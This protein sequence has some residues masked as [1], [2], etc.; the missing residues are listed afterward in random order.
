M[1]TL[2]GQYRWCKGREAHQLWRIGST[3]RNRV[4]TWSLM[5][6]SAWY[7]CVCALCHKSRLKALLNKAFIASVWVV[8]DALLNDFVQNCSVQRPSFSTAKPS[9]LLALSIQLESWT[10]GMGIKTC[11]SLRV[12]IGRNSS[13]MSLLPSCRNCWIVDILENLSA[14]PALV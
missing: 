13:Y 12:P 5:A 2:A 6:G 1:G 7:W 10:T 11:W 9:P 4:P 14:L 8:W 3:Y